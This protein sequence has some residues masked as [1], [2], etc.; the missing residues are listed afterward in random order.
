MSA[1]AAASSRPY[2]GEEKHRV[3]T[4][5]GTLSNRSIART[6]TNSYTNKLDGSRSL[7]R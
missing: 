1:I 3:R 4:G 7:D 5:P 2:S 6:G